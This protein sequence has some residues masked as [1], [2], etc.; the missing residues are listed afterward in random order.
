MRTLTIHDR[1]KAE[2][3]KRAIRQLE[4]AQGDIAARFRTYNHLCIE[5]QLSTRLA[6]DE[7][8]LEVSTRL[9]SR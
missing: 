2:E 1:I 3:L 9:E 6:F 4:L 8:R 7:N 5:E